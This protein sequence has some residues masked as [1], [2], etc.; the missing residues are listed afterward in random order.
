MLSTP[1]DSKMTNCFELCFQQQPAPLQQG[2]HKKASKSDEKKHLKAE[3]KLWTQDL[4]AARKGGDAAASFRVA[5]WISSSEGAGCPPHFM[6]EDVRTAELEAWLRKAA[7][8][9]HA[10]A[11]FRLGHLLGSHDPEVAIAWWRKA[12]SQGNGDGLYMLGEAYRRGQGVEQNFAEAAKFFG[13]VMDTGEKRVATSAT[14]K[15]KATLH[16]ADMKNGGC[17]GVEQNRAEALRLYVLCTTAVFSGN[18]IYGDERTH[19]KMKQFGDTH[20]KIARCY[21][22]GVGVE[23]HSAKANEHFLMAA[24]AGHAPAM[25]GRCRLTLRSRS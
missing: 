13:Q 19:E 16:L 5:R 4:A 2:M 17:N 24:N 20:Y 8:L 23:R 14:L 25:V 12:A 18:D 7:G 3:Q 21:T 9:G 1:D 10:E 22:D 6:P 11:Q 15:L